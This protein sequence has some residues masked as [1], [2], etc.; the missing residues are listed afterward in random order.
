MDRIVLASASPRRKQLLEWAEVPFDSMPADT[1]ESIPPG[2]PVDEIPVRIARRKADLVKQKVEQG[3]II[4]AADTLVVAEGEILGKPVD[5]ADAIRMLKR[6]SGKKHQVITGVYITDSREESAFSETTE[7]WF[8]PLD[9]TSIGHYV[10]RYKPYD[11]A[12][13]YGIQDW[14]GV[15][16]IRAIHGDFYNV[17]GLPVSRVV[18]QLEKFYRINKIP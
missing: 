13:A 16:G 10:D 8:H 4:L 18:Q 1:D 15:T 11:K 7:V 9:I 2:L 6:L 5:R 12:G 3:R 17:M 14:I